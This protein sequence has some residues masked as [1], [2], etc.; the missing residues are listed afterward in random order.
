M[1]TV[2]LLTRFL[3]SDILYF[4]I[5]STSSTLLA[6]S[7]GLFSKIIFQ[8]S[9]AH[10]NTI[11]FSNNWTTGTFQFV[12]DDIVHANQLITFQNQNEAEDFYG[13][14]VF[15]CVRPSI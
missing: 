6:K 2:F 1:E 11:F 5:M 7:Y 9:V 14:Q 12:N 3:Q 10:R 15:V 13:K 4:G 8:T